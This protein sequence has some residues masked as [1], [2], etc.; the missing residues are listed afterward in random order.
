MVWSAVAVLGSVAAFLLLDPV[1]AVFVAIMLLTVAVLAFLARDWDRRAT[2]EER[3]LERARR[4]Q[5][6]WERGAAARERDRIKWEAHR[7]RQQARKAP[8]EK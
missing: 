6:K 4:R 5:E 3:E 7:A 8:Q 1:L 2:Y